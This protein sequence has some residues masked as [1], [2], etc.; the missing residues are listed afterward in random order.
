MT[1]PATAA[2]RRPW[3]EA[4]AGARREVGVILIVMA[5]AAGLLGFLSLADSVTD[6]HT[7]RFDEGL[8]LMLRQPGDITHP[9]G[10]A[11]LKLA[12]MDVT[13][14][15]SIIDLAII[16][17]VISGLFVAQRRIREGALLVGAAASGLIMVNVI[18]LA[19]GRERPPLAMHAVEVGNASFPSGHAMLSAIVYLSLA[20]LIAH[21]ADR[22][23]AR[24]YA[25]TWGILLTLIVGCSRVYLGVHWPTDVIAGWTLG[26]AWAMLWWLIAWILEHRAYDRSVHHAVQ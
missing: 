10:P 17:F 25:L 4:F 6:G 9:I 3:F 19:V 11:W 23:G 12:A 18:K 13:A 26:A 16:V 2:P 22:R 20:T 14:F 8:M 7:K 24:I 21:F 5:A 15:G 1:S